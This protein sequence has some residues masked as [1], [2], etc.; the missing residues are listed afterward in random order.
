VF[1][2]RLKGTEL[3]S[4]WFEIKGNEWETEL[5]ENVHPCRLSVVCRMCGRRWRCSTICAQ[6]RRAKTSVTAIF[7]INTHFNQT[8]ASTLELSNTERSVPFQNLER[9]RYVSYSKPNSTLQAL[10]ISLSVR[11]A[12]PFACMPSRM[13]QCC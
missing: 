5:S 10:L 13:R 11:S 2:L 7:F 3:G 6:G 9:S 4:V 1:G 8:T 12:A